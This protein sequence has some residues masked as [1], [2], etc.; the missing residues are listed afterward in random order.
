MRLLVTNTKDPQAYAIIRALRPFAD[1]I[2]A[3]MPGKSRRGQLVS[4]AAYS[5]FVDCRYPIQPPSAEWMSG[6]LCADNTEHDLAYLKQILAICERERVDVIYPSNDSDIYVFSKNKELFRSLGIRIPTPDF[7]TLVRVLDKLNTIETADRIGF[8]VPRT[9]APE[10]EQ[11]AASAIAA[12]PPPWVIKP[13]S[14]NHGIGIQ[15]VSDRAELLRRYH[16]VKAAYGGPL[17]QEYIPGD[18]KQNFYTMVGPEGKLRFALCPKIRRYSHRLYRNST[19]SCMS[20]TNHPMLGKV[21]ELAGALG[22]RGGLTVQTKIDARDGKVKLMEA[23]G[24]LGTHLWYLT[25]LGANAPLL[26]VQPEHHQDL[27]EPVDMPEGVILIDPVDDFFGAIVGVTDWAAFHVR[28]KLFGK[29]PLDPMNGPLPLGAYFR[30]YI[31]DYFGGHE[32]RLHPQSR[33][34]ASDFR[35]NAVSILHSARGVLN[36]LKKVGM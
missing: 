15:Y 7:D 23:N 24:R 34:I 12:L 22:W 32:M 26:S 13:R 9:F 4:Y 10:T 31:A 21:E 8:P 16:Q 1:H 19:A 6:R 33:Y 2:V 29:T 18:T 14:S 28:T 30:G 35:P 17:I 11:E 36:D 27:D 20:S 25:E 5:R 3:T